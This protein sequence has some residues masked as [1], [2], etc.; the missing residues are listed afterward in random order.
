MDAQHETFG[1]LALAVVLL[2]AAV[3]S[4]P[5]ARRIKLSAIIAYLIAG[6]IIGPYGLGVFSTPETVLAVAEFGVVMLLFLIGLELEF[7]RLLKMRRDIFGLGAAQLFVTAAVI[8]GLALA[9][10]RFGWRGAIVAGLALALS[11]TTI[12][13]RVLEERGD[14]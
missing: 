7:S 10:Q 2:A 8:A 5:L 12:A 9:T 1:Y 13:L 3:I 14:L 6:V 11:A 4:V